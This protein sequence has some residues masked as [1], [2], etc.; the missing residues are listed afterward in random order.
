[1]IDRVHLFK[2]RDAHA[3]A[4]TRERLAD[5]VSASLEPRGWAVH[6]GTPADLEAAKAWD[7]LVSIGLRS[8]DE[9]REAATAEAIDAALAETRELAAVEKHWSFV[10]R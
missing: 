6:V 10:R 8:A 1:M 4:P 3:D 2:L 9:E 5:A 7:L